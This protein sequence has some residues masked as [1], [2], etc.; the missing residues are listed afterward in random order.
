M[1]AGKKV[2]FTASFANPGAV[3]REKAG[4]LTWT[5]IDTDTGEAPEG[6]TLDEQGNLAVSKD[7]TATKHV[8][9]TVAS[10]FFGT[11]ASYAITAVPVIRGLTA[12]PKEVVL[13]TNS[14]DEAIIRVKAEPDI[15]PEGLAWTLK[16]KN[17]ANIIP[18]NGLDGEI[19]LKPV[20]A[21]KGTLTAT[22]PSGK[23]VSVRV[24]VMTPV[25]SI[26]LSMSGNPTPGATVKLSANL[27]PNNAGNRSV[28]WSLDVGEDVATINDYGR[29]KIKG[30]T[31]VG[32]VITVIC[33]APG[34]KEPLT[35]TLR[36]EV[37]KKPGS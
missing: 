2:A 14:D 19:K 16:P 26:Q 3:K 9:V 30:S 24:T 33:T 25:E 34:A 35:E 10:E 6:I 15:V 32:T 22:E 5:L 13:Y 11:K 18:S 36:I 23:T 29:L 8:E 1:S 37:E 28:K 17:I 4:A 21:G 20:E 7:L 27:K 12:E 31:P